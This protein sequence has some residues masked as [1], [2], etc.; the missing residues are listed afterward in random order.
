MDGSYAPDSGAR[1]AVKDR[2]RPPSAPLPAPRR[3]RAGFRS[4]HL[5]LAL[6]GCGAAMVPWLVVLARTLPDTAQVRHWSTAWVGLD[7]LEALGLT[8]TGRLL[9]C[10]DPRHGLTAT[11]TAALLVVDA[12]FDVTTA[13]P[14]PELTAAVAMALGVELPM[15]ALCTTLA[16]RCPIGP[17]DGP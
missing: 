15:A 9:L 1:Q 10:R 11:A 13:A 14:G 16:V 7:A 8:V 17:S 4:R 6:V 3:A 12:W 5:G 2:P